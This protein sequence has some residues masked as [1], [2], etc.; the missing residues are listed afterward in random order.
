MPYLL[1]QWWFWSL[2]SLLL[3]LASCAR[4]SPTPLSVATEIT[5]G[6]LKT[7]PQLAPDCPDSA[8]GA[9]QRLEDIVKQ[10]TTGINKVDLDTLDRQV[11]ASLGSPQYAKRDPETGIT[12][13][14]PSPDCSGWYIHASFNSN[15]YLIHTAEIPPPITTIPSQSEASGLRYSLIGHP[16]EVGALA[17]TPNG[18]TLM[19][20]SAD[21]QIHLWQLANGKHLQVIK[22][23]DWING[24]KVR[25]DGKT[26]LVL[27]SDLTT[28]NLTTGQI[29]QEWEFT[30]GGL[31]HNFFSPNQ[32]LIVSQVNHEVVELWD[33]E[34]HQRVNSFA[35]SGYRIGTIALQAQH[36]IL[37]NASNQGLG[38]EQN[39]IFLWDLRSGQ[40]L[41]TLSGHTYLVQALE[42]S[43]NGQMLAT[44]SETAPISAK[45]SEIKLWNWQ[46]GILMRTLTG[47]TSGIRSLV[48]SADGQRLASGSRNGQIDIWN[49]ETGQR[50]QTLTGHTASVI[51]LMFDATGQTLIS[52]SDDRTVKVWQLN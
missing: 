1:P 6:Q 28:W 23:K 27:R 8:R 41:R 40:K 7:M 9:Y 25:S 35:P 20:G 36:R 43:P 44:G 50:L 26:L 10:L 14:W 13:E 11:L 42:F 18:Q 32:R 19:S 48:F 3:S 16:R 33:V 17:L 34:K 46:K 24:L 21:G 38:I 15:S 29:Q 49:I 45:P 2:A 5:P 39:Q 51:T 4:Q 12:Y 37:A 31:I 47:P 30:N 22:G 52:G